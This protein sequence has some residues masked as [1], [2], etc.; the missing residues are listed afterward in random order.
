[1]QLSSTL[2]LNEHYTDCVCVCVCIYIYYS[3]VDCSVRVFLFLSLWT[4]FRLRPHN[5]LAKL[6][7]RLCPVCET[8]SV[9]ALWSSAVSGGL[10]PPEYLTYLKKTNH[11]QVLNFWTHWRGSCDCCLY[12]VKW[13]AHFE[14]LYGCRCESVVQHNITHGK[15][16][17]QMNGLPRKS[18]PTSCSFY[19]LWSNGCI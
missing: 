8:S 15:Y 1:M 5:S 17:I 12:G 11:L 10:H 14:L 7:F 2:H 4:C 18:S 3:S 9:F 19:R 16:L 13:T 6:P